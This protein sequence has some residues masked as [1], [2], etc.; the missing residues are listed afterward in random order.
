MELLLHINPPL[1]R[2][3]L[4]ISLLSLSTEG[5]A[6]YLSVSDFLAGQANSIPMS[7]QTHNGSALSMASLNILN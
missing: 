6:H 3:E 2:L 4:V 1:K 7:S 5:E